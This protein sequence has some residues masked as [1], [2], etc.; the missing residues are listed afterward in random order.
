MNITQTIDYI[1]IHPFTIEA[2]NKYHL[3]DDKDLRFLLSE[4]QI[5]NWLTVSKNCSN[6]YRQN[7]RLNSPIIFDAIKDIAPPSNLDL[8]LP[9]VI[10]TEVCKVVPMLPKV[11]LPKNFIIPNQL[12]FEFCT[13]KQKKPPVKVALSL[14]KEA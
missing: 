11:K 8:R 12:E 1:L 5:H 10:K 9:F 6:V 7:K 3:G 14:L 2:L 4:L 13:I